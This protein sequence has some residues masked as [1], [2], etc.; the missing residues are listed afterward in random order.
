MA[1]YPKVLKPWRGFPNMNGVH[2]IRI[3]V[4]QAPPAQDVYGQPGRGSVALT[5]NKPYHIGTIPKGSILLPANGFVSTAFTATT[6]L[7]IGS[8]IA[9]GVPQEDVLASATIAPQ[10]T[11]YKANLAL[12]AKAASP[13]LAD[14]PV[15]IVAEVAAPLAGV[16]DLVIPFYIHRD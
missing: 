15:W 8:Q 4:D 12:G 3:F 7:K 16:M 2:G 10:T 1:V 9:S 14:L 11:G 5:L 6:T 13:L